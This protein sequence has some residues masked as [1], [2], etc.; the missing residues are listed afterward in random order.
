MTPFSESIKQLAEKMKT[1]EEWLELVRDLNDPIDRGRLPAELS[2]RWAEKGDLM[3]INALEGFVKE[4]DFME[5]SLKK[6]DRCLVLENEGAIRA[7]AWVTF[8]DFRL[9][10][11]YKLKLAPGESYLVYIFVHP[12]FSGRGVGSTLLGELMAAVRDQGA[13]TMISGMYSDWQR[14]IRMH[15]RMGFHVKRRLTQCKILNI[16]PTPPKVDG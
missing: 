10:P 16:F 1:C 8:S 3:A 9:A 11:W 14:S 13:H 6:G 7:F 4:T 2:M 15:T 12:V 5:R